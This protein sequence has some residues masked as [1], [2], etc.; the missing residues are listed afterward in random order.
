MKN[1]SDYVTTKWNKVLEVLAMLCEVSYAADN[2]SGDEAVR[3]LT[4]AL[5]EAYDEWLD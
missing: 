4:M 1:T 5:I 3:A 2:L